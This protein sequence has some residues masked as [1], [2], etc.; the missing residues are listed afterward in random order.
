MMSL[1]ACQQRTLTA[2]DDVLE[3]TEPRL[4][5]MFAVFARLTWREPIHAEQLPRRGRP[6]SR[7]GRWL[8]L[9]PLLTGLALV[10]GLIVSQVISPAPGCV[11]AVTASSGARTGVSC[12]TPDLNR[13]GTR[14][15]R[16]ALSP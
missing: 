8:K 11:P 4:S 14:R 15:G 3:A 2:I 1:P 7:P 10:V 5:A 9:F 6:R 16:S 13:A 12:V